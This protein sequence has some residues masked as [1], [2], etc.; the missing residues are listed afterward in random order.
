MKREWILGP[1]P[2]RIWWLASVALI[3]SLLVVGGPA[4]ADHGTGCCEPCP[5]GPDSMMIEDPFGCEWDG[6]GHVIS[7]SN[8]DNPTSGL[9]GLIFLALLW[10]A[11]P[12]FIAAGMAS[13]R[14]QSVGLA[15][16]VALAFGWLGLAGLYLYWQDKGIRPSQT[17]PPAT[18][19]PTR[20]A[21]RPTP[22]EVV[23][24]GA[25][26]AA[27]RLRELQSLLD[28]GLI[29]HSEYAARRRAILNEV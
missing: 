6:E 1:Q 13:S 12:P 10:N 17:E 18:F 4:K 7:N 15:V 22:R 26:R 24:A 27:E 23:A 25:G 2:R 5:A 28:E 19:P 8:L 16:V 3:L 21:A 9:G 29:D 11:I 20:T 14:S